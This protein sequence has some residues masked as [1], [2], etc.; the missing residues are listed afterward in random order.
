MMNNDDYKHFVC[1]VAGDNPDELL[2]PYDKSIKV[3]PYVVYQYADAEKLRNTYILTYSEIEKSNVSDEVKKDARLTI[4]ELK[5]MDI[6]DFYYDLTNGYEIDE[7]TGDAISDENP[8]G[9]YSYCKLG[10]IFSVPFLTND[11]IE[12]FQAIKS[13]INWSAVHKNGGSVYER[14]WEMVMN[15]SEPADEKEQ[16][17]YDN[18]KDKTTYLKKFETKENYVTSNTAF[19]GYAFLSKDTGWIDADDVADQFTW[20]SMYYDTFIKNL[21]ENTLLSIYECIK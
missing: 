9:K 5:S 7:K 19:W 12:V 6:D 20:M 8:L 4:Q 3:T 17:I 11:G 21:P 2:R 16:H 1:I 10:K 15:G 14:V 13:E 18:M